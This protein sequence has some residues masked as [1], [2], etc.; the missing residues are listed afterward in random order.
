MLKTS[1]NDHGRISVI[2]YSGDVVVQ[3]LEKAREQFHSILPKKPEL[4]AINCS[5]VN[6]MDSSGLGMLIAFSRETTVSG[7]KLI[8]VDLPDN[9]FRLF[10]MSKLDQFFELMNP[11]DFQE[12]YFK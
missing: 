7:I 6:N 12:K 4:I 2:S 5:G 8:L 9:I 3:N 10:D 11:D 1:C